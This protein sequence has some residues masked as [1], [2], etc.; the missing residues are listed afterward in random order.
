MKREG[1]NGQEFI[2]WQNVRLHKRMGTPALLVRVAGLMTGKMTTIVK[3]VLSAGEKRLQKHHK[4]KQG[5]GFF[6]LYHLS[7]MNQLLSRPPVV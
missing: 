6:A 1:R 2:M 7:K 3:S 4:F 5:Y